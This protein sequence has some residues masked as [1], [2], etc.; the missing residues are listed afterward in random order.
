MLQNQVQCIEVCTIAM[1]VR[2][3]VGRNP[4]VISQMP[5][6]ISGEMKMGAQTVH[7]AQVHACIE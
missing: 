6:W 7:S 5:G 4:T 3:L 2:T 1:Y